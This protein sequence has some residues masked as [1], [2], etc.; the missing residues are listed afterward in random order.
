MRL[1]VFGGSFDPVHLGHLLVAE[2]ARDAL[3]LDAVLFVPALTPPHKPDRALASAA[4]R[5]AML[6]R[7]LAGNPAFELSRLELD[8]PSR[9][10]VETLRALR[11]TRARDAELV[12]VLGADS[13]RELPTWHEPDAIR[14]LAR[15]AVARRPGAEDAPSEGPG[16][17]L[18][19]TPP[20]AIS[21][22]D[23]RARIRSGRSIR[24]LVPDAVREYIE[25]RRLYREP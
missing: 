23:V 17:L 13:L 2:G 24:Y 22:S 16:I 1:G 4:D 14:G 10:T 21:A 11:A 20:V 25:E 12:L 7:A 3:G 9:Y 8:G 18:L 19:P 6:E 15:L 5:T